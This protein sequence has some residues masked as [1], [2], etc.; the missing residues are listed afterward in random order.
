MKKITF[1]L[2]FLIA[3][4]GFAQVTLEDFEGS[5]DWSGFDGATA[6]V[7]ANPSVDGNNGSATVGQIVTGAGQGWQGASLIMQS[8]YIDI[9]DPVTNTVSVKVYSTT[10]FQMLAKVENGQAGAV[11]SAADASHGGSGWETLTYT[12]NE[13]L[14]NTQTANGEYEKIS[15]F[16]NWNGSG[17]SDPIINITIAIDD[18]AGT[19]GAAITAGG[20]PTDA[21]AAPTVNAADV[22]SLYSDAY[23]DVASNTTPGWSEDVTEEVHAGNNVYKT[24]N[25]LPF[26]ISPTIDIT[27]RVNIHV[28]IW[29]ETLPS[30]GAGLLIKLL[31]AA[32]GPHEANFTYPITAITPGVWNS[33]DILLADFVQVQGTW[34]ATA[35]SRIDQVLIDIVDDATMFVDNVYFYSG[36]TAST[37]DRDL[38]VSKVYPNPASD[39]WTIS[40]PN[41][42]IRTVQVFNVL[43]RQVVSQSFDSDSASISVQSLASG[44]YL[45]RVT[46]DAGTKTMK[47]IRE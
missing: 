35:Q 6:T 47:L 17:W 29:L 9:S 45:A 24:T 34:D 18:I 12:F 37:D 7:E 40:T 28:D 5:T 8:N 25:F 14:D 32:N 13:N 2:A 20:A 10:A 42:T 4:V 21:P 30:A 22:T 27:T 23:T 41:N 31:D 43:G 26:A 39:A 3:S 33:V 19:Q 11:A 36:S 38:F 1:L 16:P 44:I 15:F 46:T